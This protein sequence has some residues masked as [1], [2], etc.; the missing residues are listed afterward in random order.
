MES[1]AH[2]RY[3][4]KK[5]KYVLVKQ[6]VGNQI[7]EN[8]LLSYVDETLDEKFKTE[9]FASDVQIVLNEEVYRQP[10]IEASGEMKQQVKKLNSQLEKYRST[11]VTYVFGSET[12]V[13]DS[14]TVLG[15]VVASIL[16]IRS[17]F[18]KESYVSIPYIL[19]EKIYPVS[20]TLSAITKLGSNMLA[21]N[22]AM[23]VGFLVTSLLAARLG[24]DAFA[25]HN[26][27][28]NFLTLAF[29]FGDGMQ[30]AAVALIG[31]SLVV[32]VL[33]GLTSGGFTTNRTNASPP[34]SLGVMKDGTR[35]K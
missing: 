30:V 20:T 34:P 10:D 25:A 21:E 18:K 33:I 14:N 26:V 23:R 27:G 6:V 7:D 9:L 5:Q 22:I 24:T 15:T 32:Q 8:R 3:S 16:S 19:K 2:I 11:T 31:R 17:L 13:L 35:R 12:Q 1:Q 28:M 4:K 29:S